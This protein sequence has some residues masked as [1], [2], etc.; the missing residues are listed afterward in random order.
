MTSMGPDLATTIGLVIGV[1]VAAFLALV[2]VGV[3]LLSRRARREALAPPPGRTDAGV[4][5]VRADDAV[6]DGA[7]ELAFAIAQFGDART[8]DFTAVLAKAKADLGQAFRLQQQLDDGTPDSE[9]QTSDWTRQIRTLADRARTTVAEQSATFQQLRSAEA[10][11]PAALATLRTT[12][13]AL[14]ARRAASATTLAGLRASYATEAIAGV[15]GNLDG[16][17]SALADATKQADAAAASL[18]TSATPAVTDAIR[19]AQDAAQHAGR[20]LD[21]IDRR[22]D[23]L[24]EAETRIAALEAEQRTAVTAAKALRDAPPDP[25]SGAAVGAAIAAMEAEISA[26]G[27]KGKRDPVADLDGL[28]EVSDKLDIAVAAENEALQFRVETK[29]GY[30]VD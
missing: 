2:A 3:V 29:R 7:D 18:A 19:A 22:R 21:A 1:V 12:L 30:L 27:A 6:R 28:V 14:T 15:A 13:S 4:A 10:D 20:L 24:A 23:E 17:D 16:A 9:Q 25:D 11:A 26:V 5:L 8:A